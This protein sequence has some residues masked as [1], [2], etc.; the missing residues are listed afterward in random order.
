[1][2]PTPWVRLVTI[3]KD[4]TMWLLQDAANDGGTAKIAG[5]SGGPTA[6]STNFPQSMWKAGT[7]SMWV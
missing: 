6:F 2:C 4:D 5:R 3:E 1:M 7:R